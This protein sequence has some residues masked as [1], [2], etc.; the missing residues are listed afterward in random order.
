MFSIR[1]PRTLEESVK[2][3]L[4]FIRTDSNQY[5]T[6]VND[7]IK[8]FDSTHENYDDLKEAII[9]GNAEAF[10]AFYSKAEVIT[11]WSHGNIS[12]EAG[13]LT[14][15]D[16]EID[17]G[18]THVI[19]QHMK[20]KTDYKFMLN[21]IE[22]LF[23]NPSSRAVRDLYMFIV[24]KGLS[25]DLEGYIIGFKGVN[26]DYTDCHTGKVSNA[27]GAKI[28]MRRNMV[29]DDWGTACSQGYHVGTR[30]FAT[31][32]G[33]KV[34]IIKLDPADFVACDGA[35]N[36]MRCCAYEVIGEDESSAPDPSVPYAS[37]QN[38]CIEITPQTI[39]GE[40]E[41]DEDYDDVEDTEEADYWD[42]DDD[43][44]EQKPY[45]GF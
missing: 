21:F 7:E 36:K 9:S 10:L 3:V 23:K 20:D 38:L 12:Y 18:L 17:M 39:V 19:E 1:Q 32:F 42:D 13:V 28:C 26:H 6:V 40:H 15:M 37:S 29:N 45:Y 30:S 22:R 5:S 44:D 11:K 34:M 2:T 24:Q 41:D 27:I 8:Q 16:E 25:I 35:S 31:G 43:E 4:S 14:Y 33:K